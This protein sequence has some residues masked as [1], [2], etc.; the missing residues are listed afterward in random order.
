[1]IYIFAGPFQFK[2]YYCNPSETN[3][4]VCVSTQPMGL[5]YDANGNINNPLQTSNKIDKNRY[6]YALATNLVQTGNFTSYS[7]FNI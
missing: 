4:L 3:N 1:M 2:A 7:T 5:S 6:K